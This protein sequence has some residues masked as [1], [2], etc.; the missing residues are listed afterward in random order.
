MKS[1]LSHLTS[2][3][4]EVNDTFFVID[5]F[6]EMH[7]GSHSEK[8]GLYSKTL[9]ELPH[10]DNIINNSELCSIPRHILC[11]ASYIAGFFHDLG[12][13]YLPIWPLLSS[14]RFSEEEIIHHF[15]EHPRKSVEIATKILNDFYLLENGLSEIWGA[16]SQS[17]LYH[18]E[19]YCGVGGYYG[20]IEDEIPFLSRVIAIADAFD[21]MTSSRVYRQNRLDGKS[22]LDTIINNEA[23]QF[24]PL[25]T[26]ILKSEEVRQKLL[27][28]LSF[29]NNLSSSYPENHES[30][31]ITLN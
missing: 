21:A 13:V 4:K 30:S 25:L 31:K 24:D 28:T 5:K 3:F 6:S 23:G 8:V 27:K 18:H 11:E 16:V 1:P 12:K 10:L 14:Q 29:Y 26:D 15:G 19:R 7:L 20:L 9:L 2:V 22:A 17:I